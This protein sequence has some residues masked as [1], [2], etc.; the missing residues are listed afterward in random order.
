[1]SGMPEWATRNR[2]RHAA[3]TLLEMVL[4]LA[5]SVVLMLLIGGA[6]QFYGRTMTI[7]EMDIG[8]TRL[9]SAILQMI[10]DDLRATL[11]TRPV[12][13]SGLEALLTANE[14]SSAGS[15]AGID[16]DLSA[17]GIDSDLPVDSD[18]VDSAAA[19][20]GSGD[21]LGSTICLQSPGLIGNQYQVQVDLSRLPRLEEYV[22]MLD[23]TNADLDDLPSDIKT[24]A[25]F[26]QAAGMIGGVQDSLGAL[27]PG[28]QSSAP[29]GLVRRSLDRAVSI[30]ASRTGGL[31]RLNQTGEL[32]APEVV[33]I[34]F[35]YWDGINWL[36]QWNSDQYE[37]LPMAIAVQLTMDDP[38][39]QAASSMQGIAS[40][41]GATRVFKHIVRLPLARPLDSSAAESGATGL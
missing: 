9:A 7:R 40:T 4:T 36:S 13:T 16:Q 11:Y 5:M 2:G 18:A 24:V 6:M 41:S 8:Q 25:Y 15:L 17:A 26:V 29:G 1:M 28:A 31:S 23:G 14:G 20:S 19:E 22:V 30:Q 27:N 35:S 37:E 34:E 38:I 12:D 21:L 32:I 39:G 10:E 33:G 3:F